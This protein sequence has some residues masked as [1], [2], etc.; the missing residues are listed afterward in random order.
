V[1]SIVSS[2]I[3]ASGGVVWGYD[4]ILGSLAPIPRLCTHLAA[5][6][7]LWA[8]TLWGATTTITTK[9]WPSTTPCQTNYENDSTSVLL[10]ATGGAVLLAYG[11]CLA[12]LHHA[13]PGVS[14]P[15]GPRPHK[16]QRQPLWPSKE[17][18]HPLVAKFRCHASHASH[19]A[20]YRQ[21]LPPLDGGVGGDGKF[22]TLTGESAGRD[23]WATDADNT[24][25][26]NGAEDPTI[27]VDEALVETMA[28][29]GRSTGTRFN[30]AHNPN[31]ADI[32]FRAQQ[33]RGYLQSGG[34]P[35]NATNKATAL[36]E[37]LHRAV[38]FYSMLQT[39]DGHWTGDY[40]GPHF[41]LPG[42][43]IAWYAMG[44]PADMVSADAIELMRFYIFTHQQSDGG[45]GTHLESPSTMFGTTLMY[46]ALRLLGTDPA[47]P[48]AVR[49]RTF[50]RANGGALYTSSWAKFYLCLLGCMHW[51][52]HNS[53]PPEMWLLP[54]WF[55]FHPGRMWCHARMV[56]RT[57]QLL[58]LVLLSASGS[59]QD[60]CS[61]GEC[62]FSLSLGLPLKNPVLVAFFFLIL[63]Q[64]QW[65]SCTDPDLYT[66]RP[67]R[68]H[69]CKLCGKNCTVKT[70]APYIGSEPG[71]L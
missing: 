68:I 70:T 8:V 38:H 59:T 7:L 17:W 2:N 66:T 46:V 62:F 39:C 29:G 18:S 21:C 43:V 53:V 42:L 34:V 15:S 3:A 25:I 61:S 40:G 23:V 36:A 31:S 50:L 48:V 13:M 54:N 24:I 26:F 41:L 19:A 55:P 45:W 30:P 4:P 47:D 63:L 67:K 6:C 16:I 1:H 51:N 64:C 33:I 10:Y 27:A 52:G 37:V 71:T 9:L 35:P 20:S 44:Q 56:Y 22:T 14:V 12:I 11:A 32:P 60:I 58:L 5:I 69:W 28:C 49:G 57:Y 65:D